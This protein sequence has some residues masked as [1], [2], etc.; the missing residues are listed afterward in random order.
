MRH[1]PVEHFAIEII[2]LEGFVNDMRQLG[3]RHLEHFVAGHG[4]IGWLVLVG[5]ILVR[6]RQQL[7]VAAVGVQMRR[8]D[9]LLFACA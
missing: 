9:A 6:Q 3:Y 7:T 2:S 5:A 8:D 1:Q 4:E